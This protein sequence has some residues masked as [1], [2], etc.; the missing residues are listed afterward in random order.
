MQ[1]LQNKARISCGGT[2]RKTFSAFSS[3]KFSSP[4]FCLACVFHVDQTF[5]YSLRQYQNNGEH[6][7]GVEN[8][9]FFGQRPQAG[10]SE[11]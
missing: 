11:E 9:F 3:S 10:Q 7:S 6:S 8:H 5:L 4:F 2:T 1:S